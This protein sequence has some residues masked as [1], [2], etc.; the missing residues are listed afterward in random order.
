MAD[1]RVH[2]EALT[3]ERVLSILNYDPLTGLFTWKGGRPRVHEGMPAGS[4]GRLGHLEIQIDG[5]CYHANRLA[6]F[7]M[8]GEWPK[9]IVDHKNNISDD[10]GWEN[11]RI[12][13][14][15]QNRM[16][17]RCPKN[18]LC[19]LKGV[20]SKGRRWQARIRV[21]GKLIHLGSYGSPQV[22]HAAYVEAAKRY[23]GEFANAG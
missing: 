15:G 23:F 7:V 20:T 6:W 3:V 5:V 12:A 16:N 10:N 18:N 1:S 9:G 4:P 13:T 17:T 14:R 8:T 11:L 19:G 22:A 2:R 21:E